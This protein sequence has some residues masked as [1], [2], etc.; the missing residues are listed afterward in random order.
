M[1]RKKCGEG[2]KLCKKKKISAL[3]SKKEKLSK[4]YVKFTGEKVDTLLDNKK[5][6]LIK[7]KSL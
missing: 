1:K 4:D 2:H 3:V 7:C 5:M 6:L